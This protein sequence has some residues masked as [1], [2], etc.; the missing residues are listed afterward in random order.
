MEESVH[1]PQFWIRQWR[2]SVARAPRTGAG[3]YASRRL[4]DRM[5]ADYERRGTRGTEKDAAAEELIATLSR[6]G[7]FGDGARVLDV[8]CGTGR[9]AIAFAG[10]GA[11]VTA[12][13]FSPAMLGRLREALPAE[14]AGRVHPVEADWEELD[15]AERGWERAFDLA[16]AA[17]TPAIRTPGAFLKLHRASRGGCCFRGWAGRREDPL[18][19]G[20]WRHLTGKPMP[21]LA[22]A[23]DGV[24]AAFN[25]LYAMGSS[26]SVEFQEVWWEKRE[27]V[28]KSAEFF[29][30]YFD[31]LEGL[32]REGLKGKISECLAAVAEDGM[33]ASRTAG[34]TGSLIWK[35][36]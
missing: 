16:H 36:G 27:P 13:D 2:E 22:G 17:M 1:S 4:W 6:R 35:V 21:S 9:M 5:A 7:L 26:P 3:G 29:A 8:G 19:A 14:L 33:V 11:E 18:L 34:R 23:T 32:S 24:Y 10:H 12:L 31:G 20:V 25:L 15:L 30:D 28:G